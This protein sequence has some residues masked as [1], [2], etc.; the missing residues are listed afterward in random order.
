MRSGFA[1]FGTKA[2]IAE[3]SQQTV[4]LSNVLA[5]RIYAETNP[6]NWTIAKLQKGLVFVY[7]GTE[8]IG[9]GVGFGVPV[10]VNSQ[11][12]YFSGTSRLYQYQ[13]GEKTVIQKE[14]HM[15]RVPRN[16]FR[17]VR[18]ENR[19]G[20]SLIDGFSA[21]YRQHTHSRGLMLRLKSLPV[22]VGIN[23]VFLKV[24]SL[25]NVVLTYCISRDHVGVK[26]DFG[27]LKHVSLQKAFVLNEQG[28]RFF[29]RYRDS[30]GIELLDEEVGAWDQVEPEWASI[31]DVEGV[32]GFRVKKIDSGLLRVG[33]E[34]QKNSLDWIGLDYEVDPNRALFEY[35]IKILGCNG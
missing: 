16:R 29:R 26:V 21:L 32:V 13:R 7:N 24:A 11:E 12:T 2:R 25:G 15:D 31:M 14:F 23:T 1:T 9:E 20:R 6:E 17:N 5:L 28:T 33:R 3:N 30:N 10:L 35:D 19:R 8:T 27:G 18:L 22:R 4:S 34:F